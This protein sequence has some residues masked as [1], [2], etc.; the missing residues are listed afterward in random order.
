MARPTKWRKVGFI[1]GIRYF[2][3]TGIPK[4]ELEENILK[5]EELEA[6]RLKDLEGLEQEECA[7]KMEVSRPT[8]QR[9]LN[10][11]RE[12]V[13][14]ALIN[15]K[16]IRIEGGNF[17]S[18]ICP[19]KCQSCQKEWQESYENYMKILDGTYEC[20]ACGSKD[21]TCVFGQGKRFCGGKCWRHGKDEQEKDNLDN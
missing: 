21:I 6:I 10:T 7:E 3:P 18:N 8:F 19:V 4:C 13:S 15:G 5:I 16:A 17:T 2:I 11:A 20:P 14:D 9:I 12:K 1:P